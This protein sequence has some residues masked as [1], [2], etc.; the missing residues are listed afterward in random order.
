M[1]RSLLLMLWIVSSADAEI[2]TTADPFGKIPENGTVLW[3][4]LFQATWDTM[5]AEIGGRPQKVEPPNE[6][7]SRL[8]AFQWDAAEVMPQGRWKTWAGVAS[9][10][11]LEQ[12]NK[13]AAELTGEAEG[14]FTLG[15]GVPGSVACFGLLDREVEFEKPFHKSF[16]NPLKFG[17]EKIDVRF[18]GTMRT[19]AGT[20]GDA[21]KVLAYRPVDGSHALEISCKD[22][23]DKVILYLPPTAQDFATACNWI[24]EWR[25]T[26][27]LNAE[28]PGLWN[29]RRLHENDEVRIPYITLDVS[30]D[31]ANQLQSERF[32]G[33]E[34]DPWVIRR[35]EQ[36]TKFELHEKGAR[37][38]AEVSIEA[39]PFGAAPPRTYPRRFIYD[40]PFFVFMWR[41][42][43][44]WPY[45]GI[46][47]GDA[48]ALRKF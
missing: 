39:D 15:D 48:S 37:V 46:W 16:S 21:V 41:E 10:D 11:F 17:E 2:V 7:M 20:Y 9:A 33:N 25:K 43:S 5:N 29:D 24:R 8:D 42:K 18:F 28:L 27:D 34:G 35:A 38:R 36:R 19:F 12:V 30:N 23:D 3:S 40:R 6:L 32:H 45:L 22:A 31:I 4:P 44:E 47:L 14:P 26:H 13:E 1:I